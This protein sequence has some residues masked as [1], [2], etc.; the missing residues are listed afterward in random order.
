MCL[1]Q[2]STRNWVHSL[3]GLA[4]PLC[5]EQLVLGRSRG[6]IVLDFGPASV[7][8][9]TGINLESFYRRQ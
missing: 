6:E 7:L 2:T 4:W 5:L 1:N 9:Y 3:E 8:S